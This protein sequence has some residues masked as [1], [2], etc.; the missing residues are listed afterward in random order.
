M[1]RKD[2]PFCGIVEGK[3]TKVI[4]VWRSDGFVAF[5]PD[6]PATVGHTLVIP[7][8]HSEYLLQVDAVDMEKVA[9]ALTSISSVINTV[10][11]PDGINIIQSNGE[12]ATQTVPHVHFHILPRWKGDTIPDFWPE[13]PDIS[14]ACK[15]ELQHKLTSRL[16]E[17]YEQ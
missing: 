16:E 14:E 1:H 2:C 17:A 5:F 9:A 8:N 3:D 10:L 15:A 6:E 12:A 11:K 13:S 7:Q 4:E